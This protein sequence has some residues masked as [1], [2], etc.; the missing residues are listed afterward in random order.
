MDREGPDFISE[1]QWREQMLRSQN[2]KREWRRRLL[3]SLKY[4]E[5]YRS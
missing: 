1:Q 2:Y 4:E 3:A 5:T